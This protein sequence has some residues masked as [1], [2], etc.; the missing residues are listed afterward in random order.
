[1]SPS[2][3]LKDVQ[4]SYQQRSEEYFKYDFVK[5]LKETLPA[6]KSWYEQILKVDAKFCLINYEE[7]KIDLMKQL[8]PVIRFIGYDIN[9]KLEQCILKNQ[10][11]DSHRPEKS[12]EEID[13]IISLIPKEDLESIHLAKENVLKLLK[14]ASSC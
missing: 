13:K 3:Y 12:K 8:K 10:E 11:G 5:E 4:F 2:N 6:W 7:M 1:M 9:K 14:N